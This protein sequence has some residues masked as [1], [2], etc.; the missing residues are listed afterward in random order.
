M[1]MSLPKPGDCDPQDLDRFPRFPPRFLF[2]A[3][4]E[5]KSGF[6][7]GVS[8]RVQISQAVLSLDE[9]RHGPS[10]VERRKAP[11]KTHSSN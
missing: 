11:S 7:L 2:W 9:W 3:R 4:L 10:V 1:E 5:E 8:I 6:A